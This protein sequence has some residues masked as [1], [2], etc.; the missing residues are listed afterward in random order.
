MDRVSTGIRVR[1]I[2][3]TRVTLII[4][5]PNILRAGVTFGIRVR[6]NLSSRVMVEVKV[7]VSIGITGSVIL[8]D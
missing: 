8:R 1:F 4:K 5:T 7:K 6:V 3:R 2:E